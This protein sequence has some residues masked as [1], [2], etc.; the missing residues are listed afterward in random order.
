MIYELLKSLQ[1]DEWI[2]EVEAAPGAGPMD[3][4]DPWDS[5]WQQYPSGT[6]ENGHRNRWFTGKQLILPVRHVSWPESIYPLVMSKWLLKMA[7]E[8][9]DFP[10][11]NG[12]F[13]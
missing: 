7:I 4:M 2:E 5:Q 12:D 11:K 3:P 8:I 6:V 13:P 9:V 1:V 10:T